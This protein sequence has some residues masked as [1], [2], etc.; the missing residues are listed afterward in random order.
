MPQC[1]LSENCQ[2]GNHH[3]MQDIENCNCGCSGTISEQG[4]LAWFM[5]YDTGIKLGSNTSHI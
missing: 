5:A 4:N 1:Q 3:S 2:K